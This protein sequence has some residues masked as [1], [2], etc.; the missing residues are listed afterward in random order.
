MGSSVHV[1]DLRRYGVLSSIKRWTWE[2]MK[3]WAMVVAAPA[4][5]CCPSSSSLALLDVSSRGR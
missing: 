2:K 1:A 3:V 4:G 5:P